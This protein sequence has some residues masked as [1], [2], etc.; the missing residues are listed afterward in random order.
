[1]TRSSSSQRL[2]TQIRRPL[3]ACAA[4]HRQQP[5]PVARRGWLT[6]QDE[7]D[8]ARRAI[9]LLGI[10]PSTCRDDVVPGMRPAAATWNDMVD[11]L[12]S[13]AAVLAV[14]TVASEDRPPVDRYRPLVRDLHEPGQADN[15]RFRKEGPLGSED[16]VGRMYELRLRIEHEQDRPP[17]RD[18][19]ERLEGDV[20]NKR[21]ARSRRPVQ[22]P[23]HRPEMLAPSCRRRPDVGL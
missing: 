1:M 17:C 5:Y 4:A 19:T 3:I 11:T 18:D 21:P 22:A 16:P 8:L 7:T 10:A 2:D 12:R 20:Q 15:R 14:M 6:L 23:W 9:F 13:G